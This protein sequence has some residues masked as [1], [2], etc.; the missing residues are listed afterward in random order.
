M[1]SATHAIRSAAPVI[2]ALLLVVCADASAQA[3]YYT[4][5][6]ERVEQPAALAL[7]RSPAMRALQDDLDTLEELS[8]SRQR[9]QGITPVLQ[10]ERW[11]LYGRFGLVRFR[12]DLDPQGA[13]AQVTWR[14]TGPGLVGKRL[15]IGFQRRF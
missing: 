1:F 3:A 10:Q 14:N 2:A 12:G 4:S 5:T 9:A 13:G 6:L 15:F 7:A 11:M 8:F